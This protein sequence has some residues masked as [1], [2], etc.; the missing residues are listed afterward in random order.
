MK[1]RWVLVAL[2]FVAAMTAIAWL[3]PSRPGAGSE[4]D[5]GGGQLE[6]TAQREVGC[7]AN[8]RR[9]NFDFTL[10]DMYGRDVKL[11]DYRGKVLLINFWATWCGPCQAEIP[12]FVDLQAKYKKKGLEVLGISI[13]DEAKELPP[14]AREFNVNYPLLVGLDRDDVLDAYGPIGAI[15]VTVV[16]GRDGRMCYKKLG[17]ADADQIEREIKSLL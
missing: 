12:G 15:P 6:A 2:A 17:L 16:V 8:A 7:P 10:K 4:R 11:A 9:A 3:T 13:N 1:I 14:F 5:A